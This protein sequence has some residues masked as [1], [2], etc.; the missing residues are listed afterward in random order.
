MMMM[1]QMQQQAAMQQGGPG[2]HPECRTAP[3][4]VLPLHPGLPSPGAQIP[5]SPNMSPMQ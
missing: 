3:R 1:I 4:R 2:V 5:P